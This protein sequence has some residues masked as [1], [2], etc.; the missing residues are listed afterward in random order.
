MSC[1]GL[2][3]IGIDGEGGILADFDIADIRFIDFSH[4]LLFARVGNA[5]DD[6]R[7]AVSL[8]G[9]GAGRL[10]FPYDDAAHG[11]GDRRFCQIRFGGAQIGKGRLVFVF[12]IIQCLFGAGTLVI[13]RLIAFIVE[14]RVGDF[15]LGLIVFS[16][17]ILAIQCGDGLTGCDLVV[18]LDQDLTDTG[19]DFRRDFDRIDRAD[20]TG[21]RDFGREVHA[22]YLSRFDGGLLLGL[23]LGMIIVPSAAGTGSDDDDSDGGCDFLIQFHGITLYNE[24]ILKI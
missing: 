10:G 22:F 3:G 13:E 20:R 7:V 18:F 4:D 17:I 5:H 21:G 19:R 11:G 16:L 6:R 2:I 8:D 14:A 12:G 23:L 24:N 9:H 15:I 1:K